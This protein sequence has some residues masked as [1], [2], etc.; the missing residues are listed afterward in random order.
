LIAELGECEILLENYQATRPYLYHLTDKLNLPHILDTNQ[1]YPAAS[2]ME[3]AGRHD[4]L[5]QR[6][7]QHQRITVGETVILVRDQAPFQKGHITFEDGYTFDR[8]VESLNRRI[9]FLGGYG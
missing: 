8:F 1:L 5:R 7:R 6:R 3:A 9:F 4:L 2:F